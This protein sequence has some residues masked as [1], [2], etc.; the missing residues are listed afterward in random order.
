MKLS[1]DDLER[2]CEAARLSPG[3][4]NVLWMRHAEGLEDAEIAARLGISAVTVRTR[5]TR[6]K[7]KIQRTQFRAA[8]VEHVEI[9]LATGGE[10]APP[11]PEE[12]LT[13]EEYARVLWQCMHRTNC[14][15]HTPRYDSEN[16][17]V[18]E[19]VKIHGYAFT[20]EDVVEVV[21]HRR[22]ERGRRSAA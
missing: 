20:F 19:V 11:P 17:L 9:V 2:I 13:V 1:P 22:R 10:V 5:L 8:Q 16:P 21:R 6:A 12:S 4:K 15:P 7:A 18:A 14:T 3:Q